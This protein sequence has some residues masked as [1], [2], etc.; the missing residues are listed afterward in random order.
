LPRDHLDSRDPSDLRADALSHAIRLLLKEKGYR[1][2]EALALVYYVP[3]AILER[4][5][6]RLA[7]SEHAQLVAQ[8]AVASHLP[9][10]LA[11]F[12]I[13]QAFNLS[14]D[15]PPPESMR[16]RPPPPPQG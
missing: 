10:R 9:P 4:V 2:K 13:A 15:Q 1:D 5:W 8:L 11:R 7:L 6:M 12:L 3:D 16:S 14:S